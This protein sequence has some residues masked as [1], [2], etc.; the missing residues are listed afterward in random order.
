MGSHVFRLFW[1]LRAG[2][3]TDD[4]QFNPG[5]NFCCDDI[6]IDSRSQPSLMRILI[7]RSKTDQF[8]SGSYVLLACT[9]SDICPVAA[10]LIYLAF[11][12]T[13]PGPLFIYEDGSYLSRPK[14]V[15]SLNHAL[16][17]AGIDLS[18]FILYWC[19]HHCLCS[20]RSV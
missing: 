1:F 14:L 3:F 4:S 19:S 8:G 9:D 16:S 5:K 12:P 7:K 17:S 2:E 10:I 13:V 11:R 6:S 15:H 20:W 18:F